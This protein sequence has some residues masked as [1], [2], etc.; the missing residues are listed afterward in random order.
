MLNLENA[1]TVEFR[2]FRGS[3][4]LIAVL[5]AIEYANALANFCALPGDDLTATAFVAYL[6]SPAGRKD[7]KNLRAYLV[8]RGYLPA[9]PSTTDK[10]KES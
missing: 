8:E 3:L 7:T 6:H 10:S 2:I 1:R 9:T 4:R 5:A